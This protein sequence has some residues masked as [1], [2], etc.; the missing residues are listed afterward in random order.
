ME[1]SD[2]KATRYDVRDAIATITLHRPE[3]MNAWTGRMH[4]EYRALLARAAADTAVRVIVVTGS[5]RS[6]CVGADTQALEGHVARGTYDPGVDDDLARPGYGVRPEFD[7]DFAYQ[8]GIPKPI[9]AAINGPAA[10]VGLVLACFCDLRFAASGVKL[11]TSH[12]RLGLPAEYGLSWLL[13]RLIGLTRAADILLSSRIVTSDEAA[14]L[15]LVNGVVPPDQL[16]DTTYDYARR[17]A[18]EIAPSSLAAT[19]LQLY[20]DFH[21]DVA[22]SVRDA[23]DRLSSMMQG[24]D[25]A[26]GVAAL[27][28]RRPP[29]FPDPPSPMDA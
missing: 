21:R 25:F 13:P 10:G 20:D 16:M 9:I 29:R 28:E 26:E 22:T 3:R 12:G 11:T 15:G 7:A 23:G 27:T 19:K 14:G 8:F 17:L 1:L 5:G 2:L 24:A 4:T 6:F 18:T